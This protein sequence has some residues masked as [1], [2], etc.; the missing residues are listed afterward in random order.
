MTPIQAGLTDQNASSPISWDSWPP[1]PS[2]YSWAIANFDY[3]HSYM[4]GDAPAGY[5]IAGKASII[6]ESN[7]PS[8]HIE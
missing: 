7:T 4:P 6:H 2:I 3:S 5:D 1:S 8:Q